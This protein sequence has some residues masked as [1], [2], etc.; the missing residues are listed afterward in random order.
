[1]KRLLE[2]GM[3]TCES[4]PLILCSVTRHQTLSGCFALRPSDI[5]SL[6]LSHLRTAQRAGDADTSDEI[7]SD[8]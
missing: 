8:A 5:R 1:M 7:P 2:S 4:Q 6:K 3:L